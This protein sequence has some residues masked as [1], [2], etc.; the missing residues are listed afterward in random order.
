MQSI[1]H[2]F[3]ESQ[4]NVIEH[5]EAL[6]SRTRAAAEGFLG[7]TRDAGFEFVSQ[8]RG[9][10]SQLVEEGRAAGLEFVN[11]LRTERALWFGLAGEVGTQWVTPIQRPVNRLD[12]LLVAPIRSAVQEWRVRAADTECDAEAST[13]EA[14]E[15][16]L[17]L[18]IAGYDLL[19]AREVV[20]SLKGLSVEELTQV[21]AY[22]E[23]NKGR[24]TVA[25]AIA[26]RLQN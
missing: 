11:V 26:S 18:P 1:A 10:S 3:S 12:D 22:E 24:V 19:T 2:R 6:W 21:Q 13:A 5:G 7:T 17:L 8:T 23:A 4:N 20:D 15:A 16:E 14:E 9:A 25:R